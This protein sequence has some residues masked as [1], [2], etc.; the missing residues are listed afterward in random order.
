[1][2]LISLLGFCSHSSKCERKK[3]NLNT[4]IVLSLPLVTIPPDALDQLELFGQT[5]S[6]QVITLNDELTSVLSEG[7]KGVWVGQRFDDLFSNFLRVKEIDQKTVL[8]LLDR[9]LDRSH[10]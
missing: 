6:F 4:V 9:L 10:S 7:G 2:T 1:M 3:T 8:P 5:D